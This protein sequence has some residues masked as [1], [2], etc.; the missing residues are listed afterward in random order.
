[1]TTQTTDIDRYLSSAREIA[2]K[3]R[4]AG[5]EI[6]KQ[7]RIPVE[8]SDEIADKGFFRLLLPKSLGGAELEHP[9]LPPRRPRL[10]RGGR[11][12]W[13]VREPEQRLLH[14]RRPRSPGHRR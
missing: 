3:V 12:R 2:D 4:T 7:R 1:M 11:Q 6:D 5:A 13:L 8:I 10:R 14:E 9:G